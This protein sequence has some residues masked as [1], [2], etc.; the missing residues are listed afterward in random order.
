M[1]SVML[2]HMLTLLTIGMVGML[3]TH[4]F[5]QVMKLVLYNC[6]T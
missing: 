2:A 4:N 6:I 1:H 3:Q 5:L